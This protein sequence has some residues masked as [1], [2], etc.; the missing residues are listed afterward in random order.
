LQLLERFAT[1]ARPSPKKPRIYGI[2]L[3]KNWRAQLTAQYFNL[4]LLSYARFGPRVEKEVYTST[5]DMPDLRRPVLLSF[6]ESQAG[7]FSFSFYETARVQ[8]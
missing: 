6:E 3:S 8:M 4:M 5:L 7:G 1:G 2:C